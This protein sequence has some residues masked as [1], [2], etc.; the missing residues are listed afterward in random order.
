LTA[1]FA[2]L[3]GHAQN[4][5]SRD[6]QKET[7]QEQ[8]A[9][10]RL[11]RLHDDGAGRGNSHRGPLAWLRQRSAGLFYWAAV[12]VFVAASH[13]EA[14]GLPV[15]NSAKAHLKNMIKNVSIFEETNQEKIAPTNLSASISSSVAY[16][17]KRATGSD[18]FFIR[19]DHNAIRVRFFSFGRPSQCWHC[20]IFT[21]LQFIF[22]FQKYSRGASIIDESICQCLSPMLDDK[23]AFASE[24][25]QSRINYFQ[26]DKRGFQLNE[27][28]FCDVGRPLSD[29]PEQ[30]SG[31]RENNREKRGD[32]SRIS[33]QNMGCLSEREQRD[34]Q[35]GAV[36]FIG[37]IVVGAIAYVMGNR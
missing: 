26:D 33:F 32:C 13:Q 20:T 9:S 37:L 25:L 29:D 31:T 36:F 1:Y 3:Y 35:I 11:V 12:I 7:T 16:S 4:Y 17:L 10:A 6:W 28:A 27:R 5:L 22:L 23:F 30:D 18:R 14:I 34:V 8:A 24:G 15:E 2:H 21:N 19:P